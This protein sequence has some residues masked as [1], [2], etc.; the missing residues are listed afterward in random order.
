MTGAQPG[1]IFSLP[2]GV[3]WLGRALP[4]DQDG[5]T[6][7]GD[8]AL[9]ALHARLEVSPA[10]YR[11]KVSDCKSKN[12]TWVGGEPCG[13]DPEFVADGEVLRLGSTFLVLR[14]E[15]T[16]TA[17]A[18]V[19]GL[20]G[21]SP[22]MRALRARLQ[23]LAAQPQPLFL[24][25][26]T[27][28]GKEVVSRAVHRLS[29]RPGALVQVNCAAIPASLAESELFG[30]VERA[31]TD[32]KPRLGLFRRAD[33]GTLLLDEIGDMPLELQAKLLRVLEERTVT[34]VGSDRS[35]PV[36][37]RVIAA[38]HRDLQ[39]ESAAG[40]FRRDL[41]MRLAQ[42][43]IELPPLRARREDILMLL[44]HGSAT[45]ARLLTPELVHAL[46][47]HAWP[48]NVRETLAVANQLQVE[49]VTDELLQRLDPPESVA[50][51]PL[52]APAPSLTTAGPPTPP[53]RPY[54]LPKPE[55]AELQRLL[56]RHLGTIKLVAQ[57]MGC[58]RRHVQ[59]LM[60]QYDLQADDFRN[61]PAK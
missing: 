41:Y 37:V 30:H 57:E 53:A 15:K 18:D 47:V 7:D 59:R 5:I 42:L 34:P 51:A 4:A 50:P 6:L 43:A 2:L 25:G 36:D 8:P 21:I 12:G 19:P 23:L 54:R 9:S 44:Q 31:F 60:E 29:Q 17:D 35:L 11:V 16:K 40:R 56:Q 22:A 26:E 46:L 58:S 49:G 32:A 1:R 10:D 33:R 45:A 27:G 3:T 28:A 20:V 52:S 55:K 38:T 14:Y 48:G 24:N 39:K 13:P 61:A